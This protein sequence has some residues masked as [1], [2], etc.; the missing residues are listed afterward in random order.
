MP[1]ASEAQSAIAGLNGSSL[2]GQSL[3]V[4]EARPK[5]DRPRF[6]GGNNDRRGG[7]SGD[8]DFGSRRRF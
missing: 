7:G 1:N 4:N 2:G 6:G 3:R 8:R 5:A